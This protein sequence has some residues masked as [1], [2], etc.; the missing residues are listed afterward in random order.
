MGNIAV[1]D[2]YLKTAGYIE[3]KLMKC[4]LNFTDE[5]ILEGIQRNDA[6]VYW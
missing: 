4:K 2:N 6:F 5:V 1:K 3:I